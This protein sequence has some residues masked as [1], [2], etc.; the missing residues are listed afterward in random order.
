MKKS[1]LYALGL[2]L[3]VILIDQLTKGFIMT[4]SPV[5]FHWYGAACDIYGA[6]CRGGQIVHGADLLSLPMASWFKFV[7]VWNPGT[8]FS[9]FRDL[10]HSA[11]MVIIVL[12]GIIIGFLGHQLFLR[13]K[14]KYERI[15]LS[16]IIGGALGNL[17]DRVR[18][19]AVI[20]FLD[21]Y[22]K[23]WHWPAF[24]VAD[25]A[26]CIGVAL[27]LLGWFINRKK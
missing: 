21:F 27:Y 5:G 20:D 15:A 22:W 26:I 3:L 14:D 17:I 23:T 2:V 1:I 12:T 9:L 8:S 18:F 16:L 10:G 7:F 25:I 19:G 11:P 6:F 13:T 24:N 4:M